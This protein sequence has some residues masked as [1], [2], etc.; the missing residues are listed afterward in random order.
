M[1][2][3]KADHIAAVAGRQDIDF[4]GRRLAGAH[5]VLMPDEQVVTDVH[6]PN[7]SAEFDLLLFF[8]DAAGMHW[9]RSI[10]TG[11]LYRP[12]LISSE[13]RWAPLRRR[14]DRLVYGT[15]LSWTFSHTRAIIARLFRR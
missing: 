12:K 13:P 9:I 1:G 2:T 8:Q 5:N 3:Y 7:T 14:W 4:E 10:A 6:L 15:R 11:R